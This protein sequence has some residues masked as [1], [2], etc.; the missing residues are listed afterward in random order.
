LVERDFFQQSLVSPSSSR[1]GFTSYT[2]TAALHVILLIVIVQLGHRAIRVGMG[3]TSPQGGIAAFVLPGSGAASAPAVAKPV[4]KPK[5]APIK[6]TPIASPAADEASSAG[7]GA[8][9]GAGA[10]AQSGIGGGPVRVGPG[11]QLLHRVKPVYPRSLELARVQ[12]TVVLDA[13]IKPDGTIGDIK[14]LSTTS[15]LFAQAAIDAVKQWRYS[16]ISFEGLVTVTVNFTLE[17]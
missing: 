10:G 3:G 1:F 6:S 7:S 16:P 11:V 14:V 2:A 15:P 17:R 13:I 4:A 9:A 12:G 8:Q 5:P